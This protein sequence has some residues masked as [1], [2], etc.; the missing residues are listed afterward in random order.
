MKGEDFIIV[1]KVTLETLGSATSAAPSERVSPRL[2]L[3]AVSVTRDHRPGD[4]V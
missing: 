4:W 1:P 3:G 2:S